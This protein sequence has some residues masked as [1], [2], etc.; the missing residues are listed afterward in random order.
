[1][2][3]LAENHVL[4]GDNFGAERS[5]NRQGFTL[6]RSIVT[7]G[8][9]VQAFD[10]SRGRSNLHFFE[11]GRINVIALGSIWLGR[12]F[13]KE[14]LQ[15]F[16]D[17]LDGE[18]IF[19]TNEPSIY[20]PLTGAFILIVSD[21]EAVQVLNDRLGAIKLFMDR[22]INTLST[23]FLS[24]AESQSEL[25][26]NS[27]AAREYVLIE[28]SHST[29]TIVKEITSLNAGEMIDLS[30]KV[31]SRIWMPIREEPLPRYSRIEEAIEDIESDLTAHFRKI[32]SA[33]TS[34]AVALSGGFDSRLVYALCR[35]TGINVNLFVYGSSQSSDV[36]IATTIAEKEGVYINVVDKNKEAQQFKPMSS[37]A[38]MEAIDFF[39][40]TPVDGAMDCGVDRE[41]RVRQT[42]SGDIVLNGGGGEIY[43]NFFRIT[44]RPHSFHEICNC[45][46]RQF[47]RQVFPDKS[48]EH[49]FYEHLIGSMADAI[50]F[51]GNYPTRID[52]ELVYALF[53]CGWWM[54]RNSSIASRLGP[55]MTPLMTASLVSKASVLPLAWKNSGRFESAL[56]SKIS[57]SLA[58]YPS[59]Y[60]FTFSK[61]P[62][63]AEK[64]TEISDLIR[65]PLLRPRISEIGRKLRGLRNADNHEFNLDWVYSN[66]TE[67][68]DGIIVRDAL[69]SDGARARMATLDA[70]IS[71]L[72]IRLEW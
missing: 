67:Y 62:G 63:V 9:H 31:I 46:Y 41:T 16:V 53:R 3:R 30:R 1:M 60:G 51:R 64:L 42:M 45:F 8:W 43:R 2:K 35:K 36:K 70:I 18:R 52:N 38:F 11:N 57:P 4:G 37:G 50:D 71:F 14:A 39:D 34:A 13:G 55:F 17:R 72:S 5:L 49:E 48:I 65:M 66:K 26:L 68:L 19:N 15:A 28:A 12:R 40:G 21:G 32:S 47:P 23:S 56:I 22:G 24:V 20:R 61:G 6:N 27:Q 29:D 44:S 33:Y 59:A 25:T 54:N 69:I 10:D 58:K 7:G